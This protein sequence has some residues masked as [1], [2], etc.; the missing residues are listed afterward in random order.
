MK[1]IKL[2]ERNPEEI[3]DAPYFAEEVRRKIADLYGEDS[4]YKGGLTVTTTVN[5]KLQEFADKALRKGLEEY[6]R[7]HGWRGSLGTIH[8]EDLLNG[9]WKESIK[10]MKK[11]LFIVLLVGVWA[12]LYSMAVY[13][14]L[15]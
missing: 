14:R 4:L 11:Y 10:N 6:D 13:G 8:K 2:I 5:P 7:R 9:N 1:K 3:I 15:F 12:S